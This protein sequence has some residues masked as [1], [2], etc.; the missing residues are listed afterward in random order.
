[1]YTDG[2]IE[3]VSFDELKKLKQC[4]PRRED[5]FLRMMRPGTRIR[6]YSFERDEWS[7]GVVGSVENVLEGL[8]S[9]KFRNSPESVKINLKTTG[10]QIN[11]ND[12][13]K[14]TST[15]EMPNT[16]SPS[17]AQTKTAEVTESDID[18]FRR[19]TSPAIEREVASYYLEH[20][21]GCVK[22][23]V[24]MYKCS[25]VE[26]FNTAVYNS[27]EPTRAHEILEEHKWNFLRAEEFV[28][29]NYRKKLG[30][31]FK[32]LSS[33]EID[34]VWRQC[35]GNFEATRNDLVG[36]ITCPCCLEFY[37]SYD[38]DKRRVKVKLCKCG[39]ELCQVCRDEAVSKCIH[40]FGQNKTRLRPNC[41]NCRSS[42][43]LSC[44]LFPELYTSRGAPK[45]TF[46]G[47]NVSGI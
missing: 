34:Q 46:L 20:F 1:M 6:V 33:E 37:D 13:P 39:Y 25:L 19:Q 29:N 11:D 12:I 41:W 22:R 8:F 2:D 30:E 3:D 32:Q 27:V 7:Y 35:R 28:H 47:G 16:D 4:D 9:V 5:A 23:A 14:P 45:H 24:D 26:N 10:V 43:R 15:A 17:T 42:F 44:D 31:E 36:R 40:P 18:S 38:E 21:D